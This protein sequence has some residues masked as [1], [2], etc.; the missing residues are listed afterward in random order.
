[1]NPEVSEIFVFSYSMGIITRHIRIYPHSLY[2][3]LPTSLDNPAGNARNSAL[4]APIQSPVEILRPSP[5]IITKRKSREKATIISHAGD[6]G[7]Q[8]KL[9]F[10]LFLRA[11]SPISDFSKSGVTC[12][13]SENTPRI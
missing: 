6:H 4:M 13:W 3:C 11:V 1:M 8:S 9:V 2:L 12:F 10:P 5:V 7:A